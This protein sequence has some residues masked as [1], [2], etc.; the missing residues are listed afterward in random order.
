[1]V[2]NLPDGI[3]D[4]RAMIDLTHLSLDFQARFTQALA[5]QIH[6]DMSSN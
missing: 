6:E 5:A 2:D 3:V 4:A 1:V